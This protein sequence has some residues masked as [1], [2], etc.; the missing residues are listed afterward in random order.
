[1]EIEVGH[2]YGQRNP[3][4]GRGVVK[5]N[6][7]LQNSVLDFERFDASFVFTSAGLE[8]EEHNTQSAN[9]LQSTGYIP[10]EEALFDKL[11]A[12]TRTVNAAARARM[13][14]ALG[15]NPVATDKASPSPIPLEVGT[16][17]AT[18]TDSGFSLIKV[19][20]FDNFLPKARVEH[21]TIATGL[22]REETAYSV[23]QITLDG[24]QPVETSLFDAITGLWQ[25]TQRTVDALLHQYGL[26]QEG[27]TA[28]DYAE[29][30]AK[31]MTSLLNGV[32]DVV[33]VHK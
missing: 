12:L 1:M 25:T 13:T 14:I 7:Q 3:L 29:Q 5:I 11:R 30:Y 4:W 10:V 15:T 28:E 22:V 27:D 8:F 9:L 23:K 33:D 17:A 6:R 2:C 20:S 21:F 31:G 32:Y 19:T 18:R 16:V 24:Y 26:I